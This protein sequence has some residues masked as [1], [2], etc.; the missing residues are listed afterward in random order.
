MSKMSR[1]QALGT[2]GAA[3]AAAALPAMPALAA[4]RSIRHF[5]WGNPERDKRTFAVID[6][7]QKNHPDIEVS[8]ETIGWGDYWTKM[9]TQTA[10]KNMADLV[11]MDYRFLFEYVHRGALKSLDEYIGNGLDLSNFDKGPLSGG[12]VDGKLYAL[13]IGSNSQVVPYNTRLF[14]E[15]GV[16]ADVINWSREDFAAACEQIAT[17][18]NAKGCDDFSLMIEYMEAWARQE[19]NDFYD[20]EGNVT[21]TA[22]NVAGYWNYWKEMRDAGV[23]LD[24]NHTVILDKPMSETGIVTGASAMSPFW[25]NQ[26]VAVQAL[27]TDQIGAAMVPHKAGSTNWAQFIKPSMF[28]SLTRDAKDVEAAI[29]YMNDWINAPEATAILGLERGIPANPDVRAALAP[30]FTPAEKLSVDYFNAIQEKVGPLPLP[31]PKGAGEV[32]D[33]FMRTGTDVVLGNMEVAEAAELFIEDAQAIVDRA[34]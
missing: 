14:D 18:T 7:F 4:D 19:G 8:G 25:S 34:R 29:A 23:I 2:I 13:N 15:A 16:S 6:V 33:S 3:A 17:K 9:A 20:A 22:D 24:K 30:S 27:M 21:A 10:G 31:A 12:M 28:M 11:Q 32:R 26:L 5:W 1:R